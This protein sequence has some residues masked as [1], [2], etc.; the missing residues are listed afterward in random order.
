MVCLLRSPQDG[1]GL[2][3]DAELLESAE[4]SERVLSAFAA[5]DEL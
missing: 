2:I 3:S 4:A 1:D 5:R